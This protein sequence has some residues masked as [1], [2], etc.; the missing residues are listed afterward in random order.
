M[1]I[2]FFFLSSA[3]ENSCSDK[4]EYWPQVFECVSHKTSTLMI[5]FKF[6]YRRLLNGLRFYCKW[7]RR[8]LLWPL[9]QLKRSLSQPNKQ[10][11]PSKPSEPIP[12]PQI[13]KPVEP[14]K[15][16]PPVEHNDFNDGKCKR[17]CIKQSIYQRI[18]EEYA[19]LKLKL[20]SILARLNNL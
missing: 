16:P 12:T 19:T 14:T 20:D 13:E 5:P 11:T 17:N 8:I 4:D 18:T 10:I 7:I 3:L 2:L 6:F 9:C 1:L 15:T